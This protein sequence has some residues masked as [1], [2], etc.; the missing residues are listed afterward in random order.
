MDLKSHADGPGFYETCLFSRLSALATRRTAGER[1]GL[2]DGE[3]VSSV[4][5]GHLNTELSYRGFHIELTT[6]E[7]SF[8]R[9]SQNSWWKCAVSCDLVEEMRSSSLS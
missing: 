8:G 6:G 4:E 9:I 2:P 5:D 1:I 3:I 7:W